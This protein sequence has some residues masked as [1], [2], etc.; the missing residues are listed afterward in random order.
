MNY[1]HYGWDITPRLCWKAVGYNLLEEREVQMKG[2]GRVREA[3]LEREGRRLHT[4]WWYGPTKTVLPAFASE[5]IWRI[6][7]LQTGTS[8]TLYNLAAPSRSELDRLRVLLKKTVSEEIN[9]E[10][11]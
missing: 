3:L 8:Y 6:D 1:D 9:N 10:H 11:I 5:T 4:I 2:F 7:S